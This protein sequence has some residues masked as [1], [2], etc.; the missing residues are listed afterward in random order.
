MVLIAHLQSGAAGHVRRPDPGTQQHP[1]R[2]HPTTSV[3]ADP[4]RPRPTRLT[5]PGSPHR[6]SAAQMT[7]KS[8]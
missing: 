7:R 1:T 5:H 3:P 8:L 4:T 6:G 2:S